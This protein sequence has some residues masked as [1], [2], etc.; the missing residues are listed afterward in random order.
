MAVNLPAP[1]L[2]GGGRTH[3]RDV[4]QPFAVLLKV[5][6]V[7]LAQM[8]IESHDVAGVKDVLPSAVKARS[9]VRAGG[10]QEGQES[11]NHETEK[12]GSGDTAKHGHK[13]GRPAQILLPCHRHPFSHSPILRFMVYFASTVNFAVTVLVLGV[14]VIRAVR[15]DCSPVSLFSARA[16]RAVLR[17]L[18]KW[19]KA[20]PRPKARG[21]ASVQSQPP[22]AVPGDEGQRPGQ[23]SHVEPLEEWPAP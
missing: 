15:R 4:V 1:R 19:W 3:H 2:A 9:C 11:G 22:Q 12:E 20:L 6:I 8:V 13:A 16:D 7:Q 10:R 21:P 17:V 18:R 5:V 14:V 23:R